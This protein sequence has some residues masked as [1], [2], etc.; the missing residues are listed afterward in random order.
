MAAEFTLYSAYH[1][2]NLDGTIDLMADTIKMLLVTSDY[3]PEVTHEVLGDVLTS[4]SPE[5]EAVASPDNGYT[6]GGEELTGKVVTKTDSPAAG[7][8]DA[9]DL[10]WSA[11]TATFRYGILYAEKTVDEIVDPL[12]GYVLFDSTPGDVT[13]SGVD[14][15]CRWSSNGIITN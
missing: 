12:I 3:T 4:P 13:V 5:V 7:T 10:T 9:D 6:Q 11:L 14:W 2:Y 8:F 1:Q 15:V